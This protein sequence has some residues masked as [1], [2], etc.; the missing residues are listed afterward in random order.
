MDT[1]F[2]TMCNIEKDING[3]RHRMKRGKPYI[4]A[5]CMECERSE[6][7][8]RMKQ[9][10]PDRLPIGTQKTIAMKT[11]RELMKERRSIG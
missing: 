7:R 8:E 10:Y 6:N 9:T 3:F 4:V 2:C 5:S 11:K 1:K